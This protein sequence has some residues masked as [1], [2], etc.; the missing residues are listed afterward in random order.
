MEAARPLVER[1]N[2]GARDWH[3]DALGR[4]LHGEPAARRTVLEAA[5]TAHADALAA[6]ARLEFRLERYRRAL[7]D[8]DD[9]RPR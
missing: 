4:A 6:V 2:D 1:L 8:L 3:Q 9:R 7:S 5:V